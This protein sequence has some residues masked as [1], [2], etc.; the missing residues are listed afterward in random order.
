MEANHRVEGYHEPKAER[1]LEGCSPHE[2]LICRLCLHI[3]ENCIGL[4]RLDVY[5][6]TIPVNFLLYMHTIN[7]IRYQ[8]KM[9][10]RVNN[11]VKHTNALKFHTIFKNF[12]IYPL[13]QLS[14]ITLHHRGKRNVI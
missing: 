2:L 9:F 7:N 14:T 1:R 5:Y 8:D 12:V 4:L 13:H 11:L 6:V 10:I 3:S